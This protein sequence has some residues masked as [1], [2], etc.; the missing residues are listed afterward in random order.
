MRRVQPRVPVVVVLVIALAAAFGTGA[1]HEDLRIVDQRIEL[2]PGETATF[3]TAL[4]YHRIVGRYALVGAAPD[5]SIS[6]VATPSER[7]A[8]DASSAN[9][10]DGIDRVLLDRAPSSGTLNELVRCCVGHAWTEAELVVRNH[11]PSTATIDLRAWAMHD[12]FAVV[13]DR[14]ESGAVSVPLVL[15]LGLG[16]AAG[17]VAWRDR[18]KDAASR[19]TRAIPASLRWSV[20]LFVACLL[21]A[22]TLGGAG[23][24]RY[25]AGPVDG[26]V[27]ILADVPVPGGPFGARDAM[28]MGVLMISWMAAIGFWV[29]ILH[30][31]A[32]RLSPWPMRIGLALGLVSLAGGVTMGWTYGSHAVTVVLGLS[33]AVPLVV[34]ALVLGRP[35]R[36]ADAH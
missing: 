4:H 7:S 25:G 23:M 34:V 11:G 2:A 19:R 31:D 21:T 28:V 10:D 26:M 12:D 18:R 15:F 5:V 8:S 6:L 20:G 1:A 16:G 14:A 32:P 13:V 35:K 33:L 3:P 24:L 29:R 22:A 30:L 17:G 36:V 9:G 27:A